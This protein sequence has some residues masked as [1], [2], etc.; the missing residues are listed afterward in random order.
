[1][2]KINIYEKERGIFMKHFFMRV[3]WELSYYG[4]RIKTMTT[5]ISFNALPIKHAFVLYVIYPSGT[6]E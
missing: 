3:E 2:M 5:I 4:I 6:L 1:M